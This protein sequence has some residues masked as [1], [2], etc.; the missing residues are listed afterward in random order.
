MKMILLSIFI[1]VVC[2]V[3]QGRLNA[4]RRSRLMALLPRLKWD[5][6][7]SLS[8]LDYRIKLHEIERQHLIGWPIW[9]MF[10]SFLVFPLFVAGAV[11]LVWG[12]F[13]LGSWWCYLFALY[14]GVAFLT[15]LVSLLKSKSTTQLY[16]K[17]TVT[18][19]RAMLWP[20][21]LFPAGSRRGIEKEGK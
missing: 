13:T 5:K 19:G 4:S 6:L 14:L 18:M 11:L 10:V 7:E 16:S 12:I 1:I 17:R 3:V 20:V 21:L 2:F 9:F 15:M 8:P